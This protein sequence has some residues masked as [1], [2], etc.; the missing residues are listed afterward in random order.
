MPKRNAFVFSN[1]ATSDGEFNHREPPD[2]KW[3]CLAIRYAYFERNHQ[4]R[5]EQFNQ[6]HSRTVD[7]LNLAKQCGPTVPCPGSTNLESLK[8]LRMKL[9]IAENQLRKIEEQLDEEPKAV[10]KKR[11]AEERQ[12]FDEQVQ[13]TFNALSNI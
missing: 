6:F 2:D 12:Q 7:H 13:E 1:G 9:R 5:L 11:Y 8:K 3:E 4:I 10:I